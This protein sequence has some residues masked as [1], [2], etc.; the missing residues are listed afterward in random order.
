MAIVVKRKIGEKVLVITPDGESITVIVGKPR[1]K[2]IQVIVEAPKSFRVL[3]SELVEGDESL[4]LT[5]N[6]E[7]KRY[8]RRIEGVP[9]EGVKLDG[10]K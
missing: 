1:G 6:K 10:E 8:E 2:N 3:R 5:Y 4:P 9:F 7:K